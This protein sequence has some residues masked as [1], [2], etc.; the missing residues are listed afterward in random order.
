MAGRAVDFASFAPEVEA[1]GAVDEKDA[2]AGSVVDQTETCVGMRP[3]PEGE[4]SANS[5][6]GQKNRSVGIGGYYQKDDRRGS[7]PIRKRNPRESVADEKKRSAG[8][9]GR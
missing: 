6:A 8:I 4:I 1:D 7:W 9:R 5:L 2:F 3:L